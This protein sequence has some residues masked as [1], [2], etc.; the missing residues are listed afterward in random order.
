MCRFVPTKNRILTSACKK[1]NRIRELAGDLATQL[2]KQ[3]K[4]GPLT[5]TMVMMWTGMKQFDAPDR[6]RVA[7]T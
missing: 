2:E 5:V 6:S 7:V 4:A 1:Q 3:R